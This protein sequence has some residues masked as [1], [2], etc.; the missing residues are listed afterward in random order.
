MTKKLKIELTLKELLSIE[1]T[2]MHSQS[3]H[4]ASGNSGNEIYE[5]VEKMLSDIKR[6]INGHCFP[7]E[8][9]YDA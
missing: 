2:L 9:H 4:H 7:E 5:D 1:K 8:R 6:L 3:L